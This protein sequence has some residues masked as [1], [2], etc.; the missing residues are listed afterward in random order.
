MP[1]KT[2]YSIIAITLLFADAAVH[3]GEQVYPPHAH[4]VNVTQP[5]YSPKGDGVTDDT[6]TLQRALNDNV[7]RT[8]PPPALLAAAMSRV[9]EAPFSKPSEARFIDT[10]ANSLPWNCFVSSA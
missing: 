6:E 7:G 2:N 4:V 1:V 5:P 9:S 8:R 3:G 10:T